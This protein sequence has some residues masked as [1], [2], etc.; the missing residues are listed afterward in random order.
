[1]VIGEMK[2]LQVLAG[3][4]DQYDEYFPNTENVK[5]TES[6]LQEFYEEWAILEDKNDK[7]NRIRFEGLTRRWP[8]VDKTFADHLSAT[9]GSGM[10]P[11]WA[12][13]CFICGV[14]QPLSRNR[15]LCFGARA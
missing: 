2:R 3:I 8:A 1:M 4:I 9:A 13:R 5:L 14:L 15:G 7:N 11:E 10:Q 12:I 6:E